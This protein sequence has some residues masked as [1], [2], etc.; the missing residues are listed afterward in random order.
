MSDR[1]GPSLPDWTRPN[2]LAWTCAKQRKMSRAGERVRPE[3][4]KSG[5]GKESDNRERRFSP[6]G[7]A[8]TAREA[9]ASTA[10][11]TPCSRGASRGSGRLGL[12]IFSGFRRGFRV[13]Q[14]EVFGLNRRKSGRIEGR[15]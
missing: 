12:R 11:A 3:K 9:A 5:G 10:W 13:F 1:V 8:T 4:M 15:K 14:Q 6:L 7:T 2:R